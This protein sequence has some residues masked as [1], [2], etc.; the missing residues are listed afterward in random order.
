[1]LGGEVVSNRLYVLRISPGVAEVLKRFFIDGEKAHRRAIFGRHVGDRRSIGRVEICRP[2]AK[3]FNELPYHIGLPKHLGDTKH[4]VG[5][6]GSLRKLAGEMNADDVGSQK[7]NGLP[8]H[9]GFGFDTANAPS[10]Y[11]EAVDHRCVRISSDKS[12]GEIDAASFEHALR[13]IFEVHLVN[14]PDPRRYDAETVKCLSAPLEKAVSL[15]IAAKLHLHVS[16]ICGLAARIIDLHRMIDHEIDGDKRFD[17]AGVLAHPLDRRAHRRQVHK[18][19]HAGEVLKYHTG[20]HERNFVRSLA[21]RL[22][23]GKSPDALLAHLFSAVEIPKDRLQNDPDGN[24]Q[25][26]DLSDPFLFELRQ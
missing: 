6:G 14:D 16:L 8:K 7:V 23:A 12:V 17:H 11:S 21:V 20:D 4:K 10:D 1:M 13:K 19:R 18:E 5:G 26:R 22:P 3:I 9:S 25:P 15:L 24:R 2:F